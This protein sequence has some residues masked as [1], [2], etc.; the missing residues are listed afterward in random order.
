VLE[1]HCE[2]IQ[3]YHVN[4]AKRHR[5]QSEAIPRP[6]TKS[7]LFR[8]LLS[9]AFLFAFVPLPGQVKTF[10][11]LSKYEKRWA[12]FHPFAVLKIKKYQKEMY[13][14]YEEVKKSQV[15]DSYSN[16]GKLDAFRHVFAMAYFS[17]SVKAKKL[18][19]LGKLHEKGNYLQFLK[20]VEEDGELP[21]SLS[22]EMD[23]RN[24]ELGLALGKEFKK[25]AVEELRQKVIEKIN[26]GAA[27]IIK[28]GKEGKYVNCEGNIIPPEKIKGTWAI[29][30]CLVGS[31]S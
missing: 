2:L 31:G 19:K 20:G 16:G 14:V 8:I 1:R 13:A 5:E 4:P 9:M 10:S 26:S 6:I 22:C 18:R 25:V 30:K 27:F 24:N 17:R 23:L 12:F 7:T 3:L 21:D 29:P 28:R 15:L 11:S